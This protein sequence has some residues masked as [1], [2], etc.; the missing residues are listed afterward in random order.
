MSNQPAG[1]DECNEAQLQFDQYLD[2]SLGNDSASRV[3]AHLKDCAGCAHE[4][5]ARR[6]LRARLKSA[7]ESVQTPAFLETRIRANLV[8]GRH[9][10]RWVMS[11]AAVAVALVIGLG[12][13]AS[14]QYGYFRF[15]RKSQDSY[16]SSVS[17][18]MA[19][20]LRVG[21]GD[22]IHCAV[23][24]KYPKNPP[25]MAQFMEKMGPK[26]SGIIP[27]VRGHVPDDYRILLAHQCGYKDRKFV[28]MVLRSDERLLS[29]VLTRKAAGEAFTAQQLVPALAEAGIPIYSSSTQRFQVAAFESRDYLVYVISDLPAQQNMQLM[30]AMAP[31]L[32]NYLDKLE[33]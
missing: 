8:G 3:E 33:G 5:E 31:S 20:L 9:P 25:T 28:H 22:H 30:R 13:A 2:K 14:Y 11:L 15:S 27:I 21:L 23:F 1:R 16:I 26:Y 32:E 18:R 12:V 24:R 19:T 17:S 6:N 29:V 7:V 4:L 10:F